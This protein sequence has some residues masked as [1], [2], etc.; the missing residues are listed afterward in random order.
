[1]AP[2]IS[3]AAVAII[4]AVIGFGSFAVFGV[5]LWQGGLDLV[6]L[7]L[8]RH[9][10]LAWGAA[11]CL[12]FFLQ[13]SGMV[14]KSF[15][16]RLVRFVPVH[17]HG[18]LYTIASGAALLLLSLGWQATNVNVLV[19]AGPVRWLPRAL[20]LGCVAGIVWGFR[21]LGNFDAFGISAL[22][23]HSHGELP[24]PA[25]LAIRGPYCRVRHPFY[26]FSIVLIWATPVLSLDRLLFNVLF[27][28][29]IAIGARWEE[30][31]LVAELGDAYRAYQGRVPML[32]PWPLR[33]RASRTAA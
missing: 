24:R 16:R 8:G 28:V 2:A 13:H 12:V 15:R 9:S 6:D 25:Q 32:F 3:A 26:F 27:T 5:F 23:T 17:Y 22:L 31:D 18:V 7:G 14:R 29:W 11:L 19:L 21:A 4:T 1:M 10:A 30:R 33:L 20:V